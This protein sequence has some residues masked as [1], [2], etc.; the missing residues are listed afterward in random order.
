MSASTELTPS[1]TTQSHNPEAVNDTTVF[2]PTVV[3]SGA[4]AGLSAKA[5]PALSD[6]AKTA[7]NAMVRVE[8]VTGPV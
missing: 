1:G 7:T 4:H 5:P 6:I 3:T 8:G 2:S